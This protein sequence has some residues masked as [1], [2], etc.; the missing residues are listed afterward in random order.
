[1]VNR[2][3][4]GEAQAGFPTAPTAHQAVRVMRRHLEPVEGAGAAR[5]EHHP[6]VIGVGNEEVAGGIDGDPGRGAEA[7]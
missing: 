1:M 4:S 6:A 5:H 3:A 2:D 7:A